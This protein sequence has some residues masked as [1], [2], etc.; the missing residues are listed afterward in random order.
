MNYDSTPALE[1]SK[2]S[3]ITAKEALYLNS[4]M[5]DLHWATAELYRNDYK[6]FEHPD[7]LFDAVQRIRVKFHNA[8]QALCTNKTRP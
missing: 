7:E 2:E 4:L 6:T 8:T 3:T 1:M 5:L